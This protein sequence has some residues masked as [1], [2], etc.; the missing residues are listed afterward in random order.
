LSSVIHERILHRLPLSVCADRGRGEAA[1]KPDGAKRGYSLSKKCIKLAKPQAR[2][3]DSPI[4]LPLRAFCSRMAHAP[5]QR[6]SAG[7]KPPPVTARLGTI[8][9]DVTA[10]PGAPKG[11]RNAVKHGKGKSAIVVLSKDKLPTIIDTLIAAVRNGELDEHLA[12][13]RKPPVKKKN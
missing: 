11:D 6:K 12:Q 3:M 2:Q 10:S 9:A 13:G 4:H 5:W 1:T 8:C 7:P